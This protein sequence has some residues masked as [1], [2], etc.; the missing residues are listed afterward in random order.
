MLHRI[1]SVVDRGPANAG[2]PFAAYI[3]ALLLG[4]IFLF[5]LASCGTSTSTKDRDILS[6]LRL[7]DYRPVSLSPA[8][9]LTTPKFR[10]ID[11]HSHNYRV[12]RE[13]IEEW[14]KVLDSM[15]IERVVV[16]TDL[17][18]EEFDAVYDLYKG[19]APDRFDVWCGFDLSS[20]GTPDYP[21]SALAEL[22]RCHAKGAT[23]VGELHDKGMGE[24][25]SRVY[26][27]G[28]HIDDDLFV[29]L[30]SKCAELDMPVNMHVAE[31][32]WMYQPMDECND[33]YPNAY[34]WRI[35]LDKPGIMGFNDLI[36]TME[37]ACL[38]NPGTRFIACHLLNMSPYYD[39]LGEIMD[40]C[41][42]LWLDISA[43]HNEA[44]ITPRA[45]ARFYEKY[46]YRVF[47][48]TDNDPVPSMYRLLWR[49]LETED[50]HFY[51][52]DD[53]AYHWALYGL[54]L[55]DEVLHKLYY[56]NAK[57]FLGH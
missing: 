47:F 25:N 21:A 32:I 3:R 18:G 48:G 57:A 14:V 38:K 22:E 24:D 19:V 39:K 17:H 44:C 20:L 51:D 27:D 16:L 31:P 11:I 28:I 43:R 54:G 52:D 15:N 7:V 12:T 10:V 41:P 49:I 35:E 29:P 1:H 23:G 8:T 46:S 4:L 55:S 2:F 33:G 40:R 56:E 42:N 50:E 53:R 37:G 6:I 9:E 30:F 26:K 5:A 45:T 34:T 36:D 13:G